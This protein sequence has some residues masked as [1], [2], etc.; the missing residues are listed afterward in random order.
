[1]QAPQSTLKSANRR[2]PDG[3][4]GSGSPVAGL[5]LLSTAGQPSYV[6]FP[7]VDSQIQIGRGDGSSDWPVD[8]HMSRR[9]AR[10][11]YDGKHFRVEDLGSQNGTFLDGVL[12]KQTVTSASARIVRTGESLFLLCSNLRPYM[13]GC[14]SCSAGEVIGPC[15]QAVRTQVAKLAS[16]SS[17]LHITGE[18]GS[19]KESAARAF[20]ASGPTP[21][22]PF[23]A[24]NCAAI[25]QGVAERLL[26]GAK[27]GAFSGAVADSNGYLQTA[28]NGTLFLDEIAELAFDVQAKLLRVL[29]TKEVQQL[30]AN[31]PRPVKLGL[32]SAS[33]K[34]LRAEVSAGR[35]REDL[36]FRLSRP[37]VEI[38]P[39]RRRPEEIPWLIAQ[40]LRAIGTGMTA[41]ASLI[42]ACL[43]RPW[44]GN[45]RELRT[46]VRTA[47]HLVHLDGR[48]IVDVDHLAASA[49]QKL[50]AEPHEDPVACPQL[51]EE[52][53]RA[54]YEKVLRRTGG[55]ISAAARIMNM[56]RTQLKRI[57]ERTGID[58][59]AFADEQL[60]SEE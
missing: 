18:S 28:D 10:I 24:V 19:G 3:V 58:P 48:R 2:E 41:S 53:S 55:N 31:R 59:T 30:G 39:L 43:L 9:H 29:E 54:V 6:P 15:L 47:G 36:Y 56:H 14:V 21:G 38:P 8:G 26:F 1:M 4:E 49:G 7:L 17:N 12:V 50:A 32:C 35:F 45:V 60:D 44:P 34:D 40:E 13:Q 23:V 46:E 27:R 25:P 11:H 52:L 51:G 33:H 16:F 37:G 57:L 20:H 42:E 5:V 22:G